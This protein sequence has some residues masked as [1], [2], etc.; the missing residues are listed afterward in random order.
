MAGTIRKRSRVFVFF[1]LAAAVVALIGFAK[2]FFLP[3]LTGAFSAPLIIYLHAV[4][5][6][7]WVALFLAQSLLVQRR[8]LSRHRQLGWLGA[9]LAVG[10]VTTT[11]AVGILASRRT[12]AAGAPVVAN[13]EMLVI[14]IEMAVFASLVSAAILQRRRPDV[15][16]RLMLL[17]LLGSLG[18]AWFRFR[19]YFPA[20]DNPILFYSLILA[21]SLILI[22]ILADYLRDRRI[23]WVYPIVGGAM[24]LVHLV[25]VFGFATRPF[26]V[27]ANI[28]AGPLL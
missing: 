25:E 8:D 23:H 22:A 16:K 11:L 27:V 20:V 9:G 7:G 19:H 18:P 2:T 21:D 6:F 13:A 17:A 24:V 5:L 12:L 4:C 1:G 15:H 3:L 14:M 28:L 10:V 26:Q